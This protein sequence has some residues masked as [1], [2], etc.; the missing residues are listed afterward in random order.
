MRRHEREGH[1][2]VRAVKIEQ[3]QPRFSRWGFALGAM[4]MLTSTRIETH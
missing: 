4:K 1:E 3:K 2:F